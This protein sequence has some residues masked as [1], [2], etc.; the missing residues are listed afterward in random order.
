MNDQLIEDLEEVGVATLVKG[1]IDY[2]KAMV[3]LCVV[4]FGN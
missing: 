3:N 2:S 1:L 4:N